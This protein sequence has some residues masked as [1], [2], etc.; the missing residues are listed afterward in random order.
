MAER[1]MLGAQFERGIG[2]STRRNPLSIVGQT[3]AVAVGFRRTCPNET[4]R[5]GFFPP[6]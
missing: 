3:P 1:L 2:I 4:L 5:E 6:I